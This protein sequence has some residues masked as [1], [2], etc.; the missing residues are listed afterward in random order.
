MEETLYRILNQYYEEN[1]FENAMTD[2]FIK[3]CEEITG[4]SFNDLVD[5]WLN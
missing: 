2:D 5:T 3:I 1:K 4:F